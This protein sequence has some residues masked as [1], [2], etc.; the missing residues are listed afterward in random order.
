MYKCNTYCASRGNPGPSSCGFWVRNSIGDSVFAEAMDIG[1][2]TNIVAETKAIVER[3]A[4]CV[5]REPHPLILE[6]NTLVMKK[7]IE[8]EWDSPGWIVVE[9]KMIKEMRINST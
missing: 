3:L 1:E 4:Y 2:T 5:D 6:T 9:V 8:G 7:I